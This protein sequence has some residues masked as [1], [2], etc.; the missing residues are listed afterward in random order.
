MAGS[1]EYGRFERV[2][3]PG[4]GGATLRLEMSEWRRKREDPTE[5]VYSSALRE[6]LSHFLYYFIF[7]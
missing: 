1:G 2:L 5:R 4:G 6:L 3:F 7:I